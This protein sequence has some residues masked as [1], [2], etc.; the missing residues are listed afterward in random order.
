MSSANAAMKPGLWEHSFTMKS[1]SGKV[2]KALADMQ[3]QMASMPAEQRKMMEEMMAKQGLGIGGKTNAVKVCVSKEQAEK[4]EFPQHQND[5]CKQEVIKRTANSVKMKFNC[6]GK[7]VT[8]GEVDFN[9][10]DSGNYTGK[11]I[12]TT[13][14]SGKNEQMI[15]DQKGKWL[16]ADCGNIKPA[17]H[18]K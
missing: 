18:K 4:L 14:H 8:S 11:A 17:V 13:N 3:K 1:E 5:N 12:I 15:M 16:S 9:L 2:E 10:I 6:T 7:S